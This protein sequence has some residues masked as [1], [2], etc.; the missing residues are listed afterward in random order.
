MSVDEL[1]SPV[2]LPAVGAAQPAASAAG[3]ALAARES[4]TDLVRYVA[5]NRFPRDVLAARANIQNAFSRPRLAELSQYE[6]AK[7]G[8]DVKGASIRAAEALAQ[9]WGHVGHGYKV[10]SESIGP[11]GVPVSEVCAY[12]VDYQSGDTADTTFPV[13]HWRSTKRGGYAL[14]DD[15]EVYE[16]VANMA[17]RRKRACILAVIPADVVDDALEQ[18]EVTLKARADTSPEAMAR[19]VEAFAP[20]GVTRAQIEKR[21]QR[22]LDSI[23]PAQVLSLKR[24]WASLRDGMSVAAQWFDSDDGAPAADASDAGALGV[25][26]ALREGPPPAPSPGVTP[27]KR[28]RKPAPQS[29]PSEEELA[30]RVS[31]EDA[32]RLLGTTD[33][34]IPMDESPTRGMHAGQEV[35]KGKQ[36]VTAHDIADAL[37]RIHGAKD[38]RDLDGMDEAIAH[39]PAEDRAI[40][41][42]AIMQR[43]RLLAAQ[44]NAR[45]GYTE[46]E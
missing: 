5:A 42:E 4:A 8:S 29:G 36:G 1:D 41:A 13:R 18:A 26:G 22:N 33:G 32:A 7:G 37:A 2:R 15:R 20:F 30:G 12:A 31:Q 19:M 6:Y 34:L 3:H 38:L 25:R 10:L 46:G 16:L 11:D 45:T 44:L 39:F 17:A 35:A 21:I 40:L 43:E 9:Y 23:A 14:R 27:L 24:I 28:A